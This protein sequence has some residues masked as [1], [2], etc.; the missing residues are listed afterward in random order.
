MKFAVVEKNSNFS[1]DLTS[2]NQIWHQDLYAVIIY[3]SSPG[4]VFQENSDT[5]DAFDQFFRK[6]N[7]IWFKLLYFVY[8]K[9]DRQNFYLDRKRKIV[10]WIK[11]Y[12]NRQRFVKSAW[13]DNWQYRE[14]TV[15]FT[16]KLHV[17]QV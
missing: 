3:V 6:K 16:W 11:W 7:N 4:F 14:K 1:C 5:T 2:A 12:L 15:F 17:D 9:K 10:Q 13:N 8:L